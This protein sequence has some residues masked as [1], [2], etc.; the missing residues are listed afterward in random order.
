MLKDICVNMLGL[1]QSAP[2]AIANNGDLPYNSF[3]LS[4]KY[5]KMLN[6]NM[7]FINEIKW[8]QAKRPKNILVL[9]CL[10]ERKPL[11]TY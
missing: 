10:Y 8:I 6:K 7:C 3:I 1:I 11:K 4:N 2:Q 9:D 5:M